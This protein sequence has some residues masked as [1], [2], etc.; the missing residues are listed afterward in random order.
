MSLKMEIIKSIEY[1]AENSELN[2]NDIY[3]F[4]YFDSPLVGFTS[5]QN[6]LFRKYKKIIGDFHLQPEEFFE[7]PIKEGT[8][9][10]W[11]L[12]VSR[13]VRESNRL[14]NRFPSLYWA[15]QREYG[16]KFNMHIRSYVQNFLIRAGYRA[17]SPMLSDKWQRL[18]NTEVGIAS[19]WSE[20][21]AA[22]AAGLGTFSLNDGFITKKGIAHRCGSVITDA[23]IDS[24]NTVYSNH[25]ANCLYFNK[26]QECGMCISRCPAGAI[27]EEGHNKTIC[28]RYTYKTIQKQQGNFYKVKTTGC[29][30][31]QTDVPCE[32]SIPEEEAI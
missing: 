27:T 4:K 13:I 9:I 3:G 12:P 6:L 10:V 18:D 11:I 7:P 31:C 24:K 28:D 16:E 21:H 2:Q 29:G 32:Y 26:K 14:E 19:T 8:V 22:Y 25:L 5:I 17:V 20:R 1:L 23:V 30:L 15:L